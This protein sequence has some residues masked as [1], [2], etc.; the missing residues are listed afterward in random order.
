M[1]KNDLIEPPSKYACFQG[2]FRAISQE[3]GFESLKLAVAVSRTC[4]KQEF[5]FGYS[6]PGQQTTGVMGTTTAQELIAKTSTLVSGGVGRIW[7]S[8]PSDELGNPMWEL[9]LDQDDHCAPLEYQLNARVKLTDCRDRDALHAFVHQFFSVCAANEECFDAT[10][11]L[12]VSH[13]EDA[14]RTSNDQALADVR[15]SLFVAGGKHRY[16]T[17]KE[18]AWMTLLRPALVE[19]LGGLANLQAWCDA[20][21][22]RIYTTKTFECLDKLSL[23]KQ[24]RESVVIIAGPAE[25]RHFSWLV[26]WPRIAPLS[27]MRWHCLLL[28]HKALF[29][30]D[31]AA[32]EAEW[33]AACERHAAAERVAIESGKLLQRVS[34]PAEQVDHVTA[35]EVLRQNPPRWLARVSK[36]SSP[37]E[38]RDAGNQRRL[39]FRIEHD[40]VLD[41]KLYGSPTEYDLLFQSP[42]CVGSDK[43]STALV[44]F[45]AT[46]V[47]HD[48]V[49]GLRTPTRQRPTRQLRCPRCWSEYFRVHAALEY[50]LGD[51]EGADLAKSH[52]V[53]KSDLFSWLDVYAT[54]SDCAWTKKVLSEECA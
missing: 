51:R 22:H 18:T 7:M 35:L 20:P 17:V 34:E 4:T 40:Q 29:G 9:S 1:G 15:R 16:N 46:R 11:T 54:C 50:T 5:T 30:A 33:Q 12:T 32:V 31:V 43:R 39:F 44:V 42:L 13:D 8:G 2:T 14:K 41:H 6:A 36:P 10:A 52:R 27:L 45:D 23:V 47:G 28:K 25:A 38:A 37:R 48:A 26:E 3:L 53:T 49:V 21:F 19:Q 24:A